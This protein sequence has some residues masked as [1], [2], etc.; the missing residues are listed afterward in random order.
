MKKDMKGATLMNLAKRK[1][2]NTLETTILNKYLAIPQNQYDTINK[3][4]NYHEV[5][6]WVQRRK[7]I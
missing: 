1:K 7:N 4:Y 3:N 5:C 2:T 6:L